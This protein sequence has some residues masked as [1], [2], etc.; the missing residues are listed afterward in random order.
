MTAASAAGRPEVRENPMSDI[1]VLVLGATG[2]MGGA[3]Y[4]A[5]VARGARPLAGVRDPARSAA[6]LARSAYRRRS[7]RTRLYALAIASPRPGSASASAGL[8]SNYRR[9]QMHAFGSAGSARARHRHV[10]GGTIAFACFFPADVWVPRLIW[11]K[12]ARLAGIEPAAFDVG[13]RRSADELR[14]VGPAKIY[15][16]VE[17]GARV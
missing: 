8:A 17:L 3:V 11:T 1:T 14:P 6:R 12:P 9:T 10:R 15:P 16:G 2:G 5:L 7:F 4:R 13:K